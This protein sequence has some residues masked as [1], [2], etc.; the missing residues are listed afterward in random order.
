M[1]HDVQYI[2]CC[3]YLFIKEADYFFLRS[4]LILAKATFYKLWE[5]VLFCTTLTIPHIYAIIY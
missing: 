5:T 1:A 4:Y 3:F 2:M